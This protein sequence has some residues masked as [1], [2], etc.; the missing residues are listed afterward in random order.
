MMARGGKILDRGG[1]S[2]IL[3]FAEGGSSVVLTPPPKSA[4]GRGQI[5]QNIANI[6]NI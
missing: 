2:P 3:R 5:C 1:G 4:L 6:A